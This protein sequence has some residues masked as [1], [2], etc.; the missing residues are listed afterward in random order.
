MGFNG[1][2]IKINGPKAQELTVSLEGHHFSVN[3][4][5]IPPEQHAGRGRKVV[6]GKYALEWQHHTQYSR[7]N[8]VPAIVF[9]SLNKA[10]LASIVLEMLLKIEREAR[11]NAEWYY[12]RLVEHVATELKERE[13]RRLEAIER[14]NAELRKLQ[15]DR[16]TWVEETLAA[17]EKAERFNSLIAA[18]DEKHASSGQNGI[19]GYEEWRCWATQQYQELDPRQASI[20]DIQQ[21]LSKFRLGE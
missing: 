2:S 16:L 13:Q 1:A 7:D 3:L 12:Q 5:D 17:I 21:W 19:V 18:F 20:Q 11:S 15:Q 6:K 9:D 10:A 4:Y 8:H 14:R